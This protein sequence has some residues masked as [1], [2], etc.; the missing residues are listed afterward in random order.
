MPRTN[1][2]DVLA[3]FHADSTDVDTAAVDDAIGDANAI[4]TNRLGGEFDDSHLERVEKLVA[5]HYLTQSNPALSQFNSADS[6][7]S[8]E[9]QTGSGFEATRYGQRALELSEGKLDQDHYVVT[10]EDV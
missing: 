4:V 5:R 2:S 1:N 9:G 8:F 6:G 3:N 10:R 7:G